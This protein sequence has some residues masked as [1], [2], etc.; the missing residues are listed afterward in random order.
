MAKNYYQSTNG[1]ND[2]VV[3]I[4]GALSEREDQHLY[5]TFATEPT[6]SKKDY[7]IL[8][9]HYNTKAGIDVK[10]SA[11]YALKDGRALTRSEAIGS[12]CKKYWWIQSLLTK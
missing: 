10:S 2:L 7:A 8:S 1:C 4:F 11:Y 6:N 12:E 5:D 3:A 9:N